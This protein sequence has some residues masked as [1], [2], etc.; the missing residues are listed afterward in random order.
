[1]LTKKEITVLRLRGKGS[2]QVKVAES[3]KISQAAVCKFERNAFAKIRSARKA[4]RVAKELGV[5]V[6]DD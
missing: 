6:S 4:L 5:E 1:M 2:T 3:L